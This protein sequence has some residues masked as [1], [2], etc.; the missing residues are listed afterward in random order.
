MPVYNQ[1]AYPPAPGYPPPGPQQ[2][3]QPPPPG[4][5]FAMGPYGQPVAPQPVV[6]TYPP[7]MQQGKSLK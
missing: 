3:G 2:G 7:P 5:G 6:T 4:M 1:P